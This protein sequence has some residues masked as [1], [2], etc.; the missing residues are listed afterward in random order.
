MK[1]VEIKTNEDKFK[2]R[3]NGL[4]INNN[5]L[6]ALKMK[7]NL[8][9]CL[10]GGHV[11]LGEDSQTA[12]IREMAEEINTKVT[13][14]CEIAFV[15]NFY[16]DKN[17]LNTHELSFYYIVEPENYNNISLKDYTT[18]ELDNEILK[19]HDF[20]W[21]DIAS[22]QNVDLRPSFIKDKLANNNLTFEHI[23]VKDQ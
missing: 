2:Y 19:S 11:E 5:R 20:V 3:V 9:Y 14:K 22:I 7:N 16:K 17:N 1:D 13:I 23:I 21:L 8:S 10:P 15:E 4:V 12:I 18:N 6:L